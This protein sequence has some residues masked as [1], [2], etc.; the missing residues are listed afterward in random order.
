M[1]M[2][3][4]LMWQ[5]KT[6]LVY[7]QIIESHNVHRVNKKFGENNFIVILKKHF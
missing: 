3:N 2:R 6:N 4:T 1:R 5:T 7:F